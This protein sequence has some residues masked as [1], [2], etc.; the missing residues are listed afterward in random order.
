MNVKSV[1][2]YRLNL[3]FDNYK[4]LPLLFGQHDCN[5]ARIEQKLH[6][7]LACFGSIIEVSGNQVDTEK[8]KVI[9]ETLYQKLESSENDQMLETSIVDAA[10]KWVEKT[11][12]KTGDVKLADFNDSSSILTTWKRKVAPRSPNQ[13][14]YIKSLMQTELAVA[15]GPAGTGK[16]YLAVAVAVAMLK[17]RQVERLILSRPAVEAGERLGFLPG[18][19]KD[20]VDPYLRPLYD[21]LHDMMPG[22]QVERLIENGEIEIAPLAFMRGRTLANSYVILDEAQN[23]TPAQMK[24]FLTRMGENSHVCI[25]GDLSQ[26][27]LPNGAKSGLN[28]ALEILRTIPDVRITEFFSSD[29]VR[30]P[31]VTKIVNA[32]DQ[33]EGKQLYTVSAQ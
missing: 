33:R 22:D 5:L 21:A 12:N 11:A 25:T 29:V 23:T 15:V 7:S 17:N 26:I 27:D 6:V 32:Y 10:I 18:D 16:T 9:L 1:G 19:L 31:M 4:L 24:M 13:H 30:H 2:N 3:D 14:Y 8:A 28:D 20:K